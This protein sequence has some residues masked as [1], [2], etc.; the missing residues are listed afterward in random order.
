MQLLLELRWSVLWMMPRNRVHSHQIWASLRG[1]LSEF[2]QLDFWRRSLPNPLQGISDESGRY[3]R[4]EHAGKEGWVRFRGL[5]STRCDPGRCFVAQESSKSVG[6]GPIA[7]PPPTRTSWTRAIMIYNH[8]VTRRQEIFG[9]K[10]LGS[11]WRFRGFKGKT[12]DQA[13]QEASR[14]RNE[15]KRKLG[16]SAGGRCNCCVSSGATE[17]WWRRFQSGT[18]RAQLFAPWQKKFWLRLGWDF[19]WLLRGVFPHGFSCPILINF[20]SEVYYLWE[21]EKAAR[22]QYGWFKFGLLFRIVGFLSLWLRGHRDDVEFAACHPVELCRL[23]FW[24][25]IKDQ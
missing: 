20:G 11:Q 18:N 15:L 12:P 22:Q 2:C 1:T 3:V 17:H 24:R 8:G 10:M 13:M 23:H 9:S 6:L 19:N 16:R 7:S 21:L 25:Y 5:E 4:Q 14:Q